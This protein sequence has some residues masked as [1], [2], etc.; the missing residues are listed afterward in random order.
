MRTLQR[1]NYNASCNATSSLKHL[2]LKGFLSVF[3]FFIFLSRLH[4]QISSNCESFFHPTEKPRQLN[5]SLNQFTIKTASLPPI[6]PNTQHLT[7][8]VP[9]S[10]FDII[11]I[12]I[13]NFYAFCFHHFQFKFVF[14]AIERETL[15]RVQKLLF[16]IAL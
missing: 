3:L 6:T 1:S 11:F 13:C 8:I 7:T 12:F 16:Y 10:R 2:L 9:I 5:N 4:F 14:A 15:E